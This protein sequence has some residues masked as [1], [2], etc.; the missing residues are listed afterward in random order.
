VQIMRATFTAKDRH[1][2]SAFA[3]GSSFLATMIAC[4]PT[5]PSPAAAARQ[6]AD[7]IERGD[8]VAI[9]AMLKD[10]DKRGCTSAEVSKQLAEERPELNQLAAGLKRTSINVRVET[11]LRSSEHHP[12][13][14]EDTSARAGDATVGFSVRQQNDRVW[15]Q[16]TYFSGSAS[17][18]G[19]L[20][21]LLMS[22]RQ[23]PFQ[24]LL[25]VLSIE[26]RRRLATL[27]EALERDL[28]AAEVFPSVRLEAPLA[29]EPL[30]ETANAATDRA[31]AKL[32]GA[33]SGT[34]VVLPLSFGHWVRLVKEQGLWYTQGWE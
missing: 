31:R 3:L 19:A 4:Q 17:P 1:R 9:H 7:A 10:D 30:A 22:L 18:R 24:G 14:S 29:S 33:A 32:V 11:W 13:E 20:L 5:L 6:L 16:D 15:V 12:G 34:S 2:F 27:A 26:P 28:T 23:R 8:S 25:R 21:A